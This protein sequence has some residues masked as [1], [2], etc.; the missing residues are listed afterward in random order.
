MGGQVSGLKVACTFLAADIGAS[1]TIVDYPNAIWHWGAA[2][3]VNATQAAAGP[4]IVSAPTAAQ[5]GITTADINRSVEGTNIPAGDFIKNVS[6]TTVTLAK[7][8]TVALGGAPGQVL[9]VANT[10]SRAVTDGVTSAG[11]ATVTSATAH[12]C[13][14]YAGNTCF[15]KTDVGKAISGGS[16]PDGATI[17][18]VASATSVTIVCTGCI[19]TAISAIQAGS[20]L[21]LSIEPTS[22]ST[23]TRLIADAHFNSTTVIC[24]NS[25]KFAATDVGLPVAAAPGAP[26][27]GANLRITAV[28][29]SGSCGTGLGNGSTATLGGGTVTADALNST[30]THNIVVGKPLKTAPASGN[31]AGQLAIGLAVNP[32]LSPTSPPC[33]ANKTSAF[34]IQLQWQNPADYDTHVA[35]NTSDTDFSF[36]LTTQTVPPTTNAELLFKTN[37]TSFAGFLYQGDTTRN[38]TLAA[39]GGTTNLSPTITSATAAFTQ[40]DVGAH[41]VSNV[42]NAV[43][44]RAFILKVNSATSAT[45]NTPATATSSVNAFTIQNSWM[46]KYAFLPTGLGICP[47]TNEVQALAIN[48]LSVGAVQVPTNTGPAGTTQTRALVANPQGTSKAFTGQTGLTYGAFFV[49]GKPDVNQPTNSNACTVS[50]PNTPTYPCGNG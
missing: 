6:G 47:S 41:V 5:A 22:P 16:L 21:N 12:F 7:P 43:P 4:T 32:A 46:V 30:T 35:A 20:A 36:G 39:N 24:S 11:S 28:G 37:A 26:A 23:S 2:R 14:A 38:R 27:L 13:A 49:S 19:G 9:T 1:Q 48:G 8:T 42:A 33:S 29:V 44:K 17:S 18:A 40:Q 50:S 25:A 15:G 34:Q 3:L 10:D 31:T 45:L